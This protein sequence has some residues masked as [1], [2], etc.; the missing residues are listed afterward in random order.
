[1]LFPS[2]HG[3]RIRRQS[4]HGYRSC[5]IGNRTV[6]QLPPVVPTPAHHP[7]TWLSDA[8]VVLAGRDRCD[9]RIQS[10]HQPGSNAID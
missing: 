1:M 7:A 2:G 9:I 4:R 3:C 10:D 6:A 8:C 5:A